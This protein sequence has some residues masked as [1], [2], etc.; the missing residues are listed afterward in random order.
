ML[1]VLA[2]SSFVPSANA[3]AVPD[4]NAEAM[5]NMRE[6]GAIMK[7]Y[8][9]T[10]DHFPNTA[11]ESDSLLKLLYKKINMTDPDTTMYV[12]P[13]GKYRTFYHYAIAED[14]SYKSIP[15]VNGIAKIPD[16]FSGPP[17]M[18]IIMTDGHDH[19]I[20]WAAGQNGKP[21]TVGDNAVYFEQT[22]QKKDAST[23]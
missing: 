14:D 23:N 9:S 5:R 19:C 2:A 16:S 3:Q 15:V 8:A 10:H 21:I 11:D 22:I 4:L 1:S 7:E 6:I 13:E 12:K 18:M 20:G 17:G